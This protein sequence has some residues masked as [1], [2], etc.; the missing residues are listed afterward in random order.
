[1]PR[2]LVLST[3]L[4]VALASTGA[5]RGEGLRRFAIVVG[6]N[7]GGGDTRPLLFAGDDARKVHDILTRIGGVR[8]DDAALLVDR[9]A[10]DLVAALADVD[11]KA[12]AAA[13]QGQQSTLLVYFS[14][15]AKDGAL[16]LGDTALPLEQL[17]PR[18]AGTATPVRI[19]IFVSCRARHLTR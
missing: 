11:G 12:R 9:G 14:G 4:V 19:G 3:A 6:N 7:R 18:I 13:A 15:H 1:M 5:A 17:K 8:P 16:R 2:S 10:A